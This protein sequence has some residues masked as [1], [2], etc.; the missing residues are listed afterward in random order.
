[1]I[2]EFSTNHLKA[3]KRTERY[4]SWAGVEI[5]YEESS[6]SSDESDTVQRDLEAPWET[7]VRRTI[8]FIFEEIRSLY[9]MSTLLRRSR[10]SSKYMDLDVSVA[11]S[12][13]TL[14]DTP[15]IAHIVEKIQQWRSLTIPPMIG[16]VKQ[17]VKLTQGV[18]KN[19]YQPAEIIDIMFLYQRLIR[20]SEVRRRQL[21]YWMNHPD[22]HEPQEKVHT[23]LESPNLQEDSY[24]LAKHISLSTATETAVEDKAETGQRRSFYDRSVI[25]PTN[26][27]V[28]NVPH[29]SETYPILECPYCHTV[30]DL[31]TMRDGES[32]E[33]VFKTG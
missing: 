11:L 10:D 30:L 5:E 18:I 8:N 7:R 1:M 20:A 14:G 28:P 17:Q 9:R 13:S 4:S 2:L 32:W 6:S 21:D 25:G 24:T 22:L 31:E 33:Y 26:S 19:N 23:P 3:I 12:R 15:H 29:G 16:G 27:M